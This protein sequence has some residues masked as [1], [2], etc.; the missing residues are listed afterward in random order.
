MHMH[1]LSCLPSCTFVYICVSIGNHSLPQN[2]SLLLAFCLKL[3]CVTLHSVHNLS[4]YFQN[5]FK[6]PHLEFYFSCH[7]NV[8]LEEVYSQY[9]L[10][11]S[12][13]C[14]VDTSTCRILVNTWWNELSKCFPNYNTVHALSK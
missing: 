14:P 11:L 13:D 7:K 1:T 6:M 12:S 5:K 2:S 3:F 10:N 8:C 9:Y 4:Y